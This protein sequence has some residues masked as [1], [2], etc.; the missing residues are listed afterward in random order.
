MITGRRLNEK[1]KVGAVHSLYRENGYWYHAL[2]KFPGAL[3][4]A[5]GYVLFKTAATTKSVSRSRKD[6][7]RTTSMFSALSQ[8]CRST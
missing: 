8:P 2:D 7:I 3:F 6:L 5:K 4:D 1:Y